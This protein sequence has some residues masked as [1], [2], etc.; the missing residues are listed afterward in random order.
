MTIPSIFQ[1]VYHDR[2]GIAGL[3][4]LAFGVGLMAGSQIN[5][6]YMDRVYKYLKSR[7]GGVG[8]PEFRLREFQ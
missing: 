6:R 2:L 4:Y 8:K 1:D 7:N 5:A 3:H